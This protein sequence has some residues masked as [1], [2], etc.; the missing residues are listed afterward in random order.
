MKIEVR[1]VSKSFKNIDVLR[2]INITLEQGKIYGLIGRNGSG[3]S[4]FLKMLCAFYEPTSGE[5]LYDGINIIKEKKF[6]PNTRALIEKPSF[7]PDISGYENLELLASI[8]DIIGRSEIIDALEKTNLLSE[9]DKKYSDYSLGMK[10]KLGIAQV[11]MEN[12]NIMILDEPFNGIEEKTA[13]KLRK[14]LK[15]EKTNKIIIIASHIK[16]DIEGLADI[17]YTFDDGTIKRTK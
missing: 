6:P 9:K 3:K 14:F 17:I 11:I 15:E 1:N 2:N 10:Q 13:I 7:I 4:V 12:P 8:Q 5:I 16:D